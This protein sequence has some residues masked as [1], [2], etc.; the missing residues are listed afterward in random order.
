MNQVAFCPVDDDD[1]ERN[2]IRCTE[3]QLLTAHFILLQC[4]VQLRA[5]RSR[6]H[7]IMNQLRRLVQA[8]VL[9]S[10]HHI[11]ARRGRRSQLAS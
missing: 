8:L 1:Q 6:L 10:F 4:P 2:T 3:E 7:R 5:V 11:H 9:L